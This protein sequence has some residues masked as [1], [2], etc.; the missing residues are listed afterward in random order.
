VTDRDSQ[1]KSELE[2][3]LDQMESEFQQERVSLNREVEAEK[4]ARFELLGLNQQL[5]K[6]AESTI[7]SL[8]AKENDLKGLSSD[9]KIARKDA[10]SAKTAQSALHDATLK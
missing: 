7:A 10:L 9:F 3:K 8:E 1:E 2:T 6:E 4:K 5:Q